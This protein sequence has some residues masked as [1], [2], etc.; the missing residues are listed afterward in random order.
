M[1]VKAIEFVTRHQVNVFLDEFNRE[2]V[3]SYIQVKAAISE[4]GVIG[5][6]NK[7]NLFS[8]W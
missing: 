5:Y 1:P 8:V 2:E 4:A 3:S 7:G 6:F